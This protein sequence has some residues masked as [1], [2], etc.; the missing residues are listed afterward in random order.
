MIT[1]KTNHGDIKIELDFENTPATAKNF[2]QYAEDGFYKNK[3]FHRVI[4]GFMIQGGGFEAGMD[5]AKTRS[6]IDNE[7]DQGGKNV[8]GSLAMART[9][10][11]HS[12][13]AQFFVNLTDNDFLNHS[14][15]NPQGWGYCVFG[16]VVEGMDAVD[17]IA[18][19]ETGNSGHHGDVPV[20][21]VVIEDVI[22]ESPA[23]AA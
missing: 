1:F 16:Q 20:E 4:P 18:K 22:V 14:G 15:K 11:P 13:S 9:S 17:A 2:Q 3:I 5:E 10:D 12:A 21:D 23:A 19:L 7:A 6:P 8:R